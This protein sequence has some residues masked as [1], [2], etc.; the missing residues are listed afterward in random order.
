MFFFS[1]FDSV[2]DCFV[3]CVFRFC[4]GRNRGKGGADGYR[5]LFLVEHVRKRSETVNVFY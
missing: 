3:L 5:Y 4:F 1:V 2:F